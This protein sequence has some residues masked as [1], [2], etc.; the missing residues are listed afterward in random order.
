MKSVTRFVV[1]LLLLFQSAANLDEDM[2]EL[3]LL[4]MDLC[5]AVE[6]QVLGDFA[7]SSTLYIDGP[8]AAL[9]YESN[10]YCFFAP[11]TTTRYDIQDWNKN[12]DLT[13]SSISYGTDSGESCQVRNG[14]RRAYQEPS[15]RGALEQE[16][17]DCHSRGK[18]VVLTGH[19]MGGAV[20][21]VAAIPLHDVNPMI[22]TFG[23][24]PAIVGDC[25]VI[26]ADKYFRFE[27]TKLNQGL[28]LHIDY[29]PVP[30]FRAQA[31]QIG[32]I[33]I[34]GEDTNNVVGYGDGTSP[35]IIKYGLDVDAH[36]SAAYRARLVSYQGKSIGT[37]GW[38]TGFR[39]NLNEECKSGK[40]NGGWW[41]GTSGR[42][43]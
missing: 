30:Q 32:S 1:C 34:L 37:D 7:D 14:Y 40:C 15:Y 9:V 18:Q 19:S 35:S 16:I 8:N 22:I 36:F 27:N 41:F 20:A 17:R 42:C 21:S 39:C 29:D 43:T 24:P 11:D 33:F 26:D 3:S 10:D 5:L 28:S 23:Q 31:N 25:P 2:M 12:L 13:V 38:N 4:S 6:S